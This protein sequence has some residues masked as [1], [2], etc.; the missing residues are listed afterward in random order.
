MNN[1]NG[2]TMKHFMYRTITD[3]YGNPVFTKIENRD[4][5]SVYMC[6]VKSLLNVHRYLIAFV[7]MDVYF[8]GHEQSL[9][10]LKWTTF[11]TRSLKENYNIK[12]F[13]HTPLKGG[14]YSTHI[15]RVHKDEKQSVYD[16]TELP[17]LIT[18]L[19]DEHMM[20][21]YPDTGALNSGLET[22]NTILVF[23]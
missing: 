18:L 13:I 9:S 22:Y 10:N 21:D 11:Q 7:D 15:A 14:V 16:T 1:A 3:Y 23:K 12:P 20:Y 4:N 2:Q 5:H 6:K 19:V 17:V 8:K